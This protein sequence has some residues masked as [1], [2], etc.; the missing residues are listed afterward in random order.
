M[1]TRLET[2]DQTRSRKTSGAADCE[3]IEMPPTAFRKKTFSLASFGAVSR[4]AV[5]TSPTLVRALVRPKTSP[6]LREKVMLSVTSVNDCRYCSWVHTDL[7]LRNGVELDEL[8][9][10]LGGDLAAIDDERE[11]VA[12][13]YA[14]HFASSDGRPDSEAQAAFARAWSPK[15]QREIRAYIAAITY[16]NL[17]GNSFDAWLARFRGIRVENGHAFAEALAAILAA[18]VLIAIRVRRRQAEKQGT[19][20]TW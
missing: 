14:Q 5:L 7:A 8:R 10:T 3:V 20:V 12:I 13:L 19:A 17:S 15:E 6:A 2:E 16:A 1:T 11:A 4:A 9:D 18:P